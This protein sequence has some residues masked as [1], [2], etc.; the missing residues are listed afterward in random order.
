MKIAIDAR[1]LHGKPTGVGRFL[2]ELLAAWKV[3]PEARAHEFIPLAPEDSPS[4]GGTL[5]EQMVLPAL[6]RD[7]GAD[8]LFAP[9]YSGPILPPIPMVLVIHDV[10]FAA[11]PEWFAWREGA[12]RRTVV[13]L[14]ARAAAR[15]ITV[16]QFSK[17]EIVAYLGIDPSKISVV[18]PGVSFSPVGRAFMA[19]PDSADHKGLRHGAQ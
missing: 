1:E 19:R 10:S 2:G 15:V 4:T 16:S 9:A 17:R 14:A 11:H 6:A 18:Y 12:R 7:S 8:V 3:M 13:Q 5:W